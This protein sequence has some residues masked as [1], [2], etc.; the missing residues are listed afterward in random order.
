LNFWQLFKV[1]NNHQCPALKDME[2]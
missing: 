1:G 2:W